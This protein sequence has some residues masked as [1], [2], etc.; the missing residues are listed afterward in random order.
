[1]GKTLSCITTE[2][3]MS[4][5][6]V[7]EAAIIGAGP[8]GLTAALQLKR[9]GIPAVLFEARLVGGLLHNANLVENYPGFPGGIPGV[10]LVRRFTEQIMRAGVQVTLGEVARLDHDGVVFN[11]QTQRNTYLARTAILA[12]GTKAVTFPRAMIPEEVQE[13]VCYEVYP[14]RDLQEARIVIVGA[15]DAAFDYALNLAQRNEVLVINRSDSLKCLPLLWERAQ[16]SKDIAYQP[17]TRVTRLSRQPDGGLLISTTGLDGDG[18]L[19]ADYLIGA[20]GRMPRLD[21]LSGLADIKNLQAEG[22]LH[23]IGD[24]HRGMYR[25]TAIAVG[26]GMLAAMKI[27]QYLSAIRS[28]NYKEQG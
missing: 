18:Q 5:T 17:F 13:R 27:Y 9:Y 16:A 7:H 1:M 12:A 11:L 2:C 3:D 15:G 20:L 21:L 26:D 19:E 28:I 6:T 14:L 8:A 10:D 4:D 22:K 25:Q 23:I 24:I